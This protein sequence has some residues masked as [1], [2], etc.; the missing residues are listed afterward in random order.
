MPDASGSSGATPSS[1]FRRV[2]V[3]CGS[4]SGRDPAYEAAAAAT[5]TALAS[6]GIVTVYGGGSAGLM[7]ALATAALAAGGQVIGVL[8]TGLFPDGVTATPLRDGHPGSI[9]ILEVPDMHARK[10]QFHALAD[11][12]V[13]LPGGLGTLEE[14][15]EVATWAQIG[16]HESPIGFF[17]VNGYFGSLLDWVDRAVDDGF[18]KPSNRDALVRASDIDDLLDR[19]AEREPD[20]S[21]KWI[22]R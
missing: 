1:P 21:S 20:R 22:D 5:G 6:R 2:C 14:M 4:S 19:L 10:A 9:E 12:Y 11:A 16:L 15:A 13:V 8:P 18:L 17:D 3:F 7:G